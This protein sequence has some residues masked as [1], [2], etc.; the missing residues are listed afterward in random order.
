MASRSSSQG[1]QASP[2]QASHANGGQVGSTP[3]PSIVHRKSRRTTL[4]GAGSEMPTSSRLPATGG[5]SKAAKSRPFVASVVRSTCFLPSGVVSTWASVTGTIG[6]SSSVVK[7]TASSV[8]V[9][10]V[11]ACVPPAIRMASGCA[12]ESQNVISPRAAAGGNR[13]T[14]IS[15]RN[16]T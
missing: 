15:S 13:R 8:S 9:R 11:A 2:V 5:A 4:A 14:P 7:T 6:R 1:V 12:A 10:I 3:T 16:L